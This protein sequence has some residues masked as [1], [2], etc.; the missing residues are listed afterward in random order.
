TIAEVEELVEVGSIDPNHVHTP[1]IFVKRIFQGEKYEKRI[2][3][4][5]VQPAAGAIGASK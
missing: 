2:E 4:R 3:R 1:G 5:T